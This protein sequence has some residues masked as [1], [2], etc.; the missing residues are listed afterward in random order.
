VVSIYKALQILF[1][2]AEAADAWLHKPNR[3]WEGR[4]AID[5]ML[6]GKLTDIYAVR[7]YID[8]QRGG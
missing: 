7:S 5:V 2:S 1:Q 8:A 4:S 3:Y 6:G